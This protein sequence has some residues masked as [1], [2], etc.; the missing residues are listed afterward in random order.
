MIR[1]TD[2]K[3]TSKQDFIALTEDQ[4]EKQDFSMNL[5]LQLLT[6]TV[7]REELDWYASVGALI[8]EHFQLI[9]ITEFIPQTFLNLL[10]IIS[11]ISTIYQSRLTC[12]P[13]FVFIL[14]QALADLALAVVVVIVVALRHEPGGG[15]VDIERKCFLQMGIWLGII[16]IS[17]LTTTLL[18]LD[19][20][21]YITTTFQYASIMTPGRLVMSLLTCWLVPAV[22][23]G[24]F[25]LTFR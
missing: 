13:V 14:N 15:V 2:I 5:T 1:L 4:Q 3:E 11:T 23:T 6:S 7:G 9:S 16:L 18:T 25:L 17:I 21:L 12:K 20:L 10:V 22:N 19:R 8:R 24:V